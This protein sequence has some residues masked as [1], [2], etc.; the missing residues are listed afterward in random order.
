MTRYRKKPVEVE[1]FRLGIDEP[2]CWW[3]GAV[4]KNVVKYN[5]IDGR[6]AVIHTLE[7]D[8]EAR[9]GDFIIQGVRGELY[10]CKPDIFWETYEV[11]NE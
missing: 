5:Q 6:S 4:A 11:V 3:Y 9:Y 10:P 8:M 1:A 2:P 7:G